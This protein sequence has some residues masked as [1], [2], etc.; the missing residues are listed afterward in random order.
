MGC[1][2]GMIKYL[3]FI[4]NF[5]FAVCGL[6]I[7]TIG[8]VVHLQLSNV[9]KSIDMNIMFPSITLIVVGSIIF[10][11]S[12]FGCCG[13]IRESH[14]MTVTFASC[15]LF[16]LLIQVAVAVYAFV[17]VKNDKNGV[18]VVDNYRKIFNG[19]PLNEENKQFVNVIQASF[20]CCGVD[21]PNDYRK[22]GNYS[23]NPPYS[24]CGKS[25]GEMCS[26]SESYKNGCG[27]Q[28]TN[29]LRTAGTVLGSVAIGI[30]GVELVG[31]IFAL[32]LANSIKNAERRGYRV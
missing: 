2:M 20:Q 27:E 29:A 10:L 4:F 14:C 18:D 16:I 7:L 30:A 22:L 28:L 13:A 5:I 24:C 11:I 21:G 12:F 31:I 17:V 1:G 23:G 8:V 6:G 3:L 9:T 26:I 32:C 25:E 19:Y 15:L